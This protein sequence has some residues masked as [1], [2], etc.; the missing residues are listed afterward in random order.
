MFV[1]SGL[2][3]CHV[4]VPRLGVESELQ[5]PACVYA[6][7]TAVWDPR[8]RLSVK[9]YT[10]YGFQSLPLNFQIGDNL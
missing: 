5:V 9:L 10:A 2:H 7:A 4:Q 6:T 3:V 8:R 1:F